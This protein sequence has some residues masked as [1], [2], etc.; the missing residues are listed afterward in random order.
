MKIKSR[1]LYFLQ[2]ISIAA[3]GVLIAVSTGNYKQNRDNQKYVDKTLLAI[4]NE[5][6][7]SRAEIDTVYSRHPKL[8]ETL[9]SHTGSDE[10]TLGEPI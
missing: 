1:I 3:I 2:E 8:Y 10:K 5:I 7:L 9:K 6:E 4:E